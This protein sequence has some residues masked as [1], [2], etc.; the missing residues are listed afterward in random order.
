VALWI[1]EGLAKP[2]P[3]TTSRPKAKATA[4]GHPAKRP[5]DAID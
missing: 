1:A 4:A 5:D 3:K 2:A